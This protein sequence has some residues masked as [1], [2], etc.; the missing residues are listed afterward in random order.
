MGKIPLV[1][2]ILMIGVGAV[3]ETTTMHQSAKSTSAPATSTEADPVTFQEPFPT[4]LLKDLRELLKINTE[5]KNKIGPLYEKTSGEDEDL[6]RE[7]WI[8]N[9]PLLK[10]DIDLKGL[11]GED[12]IKYTEKEKAR[13]PR[14]MKNGIGRMIS[15]VKSLRSNSQNE[16]VVETMNFLLAD[17]QIPEF[18][19]I[20]EKI[21]G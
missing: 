8:I 21:F 1:L 11:L 14:K 2:L 3:P 19:K 7:L 12:D 16:T 6:S 18:L 13:V 10:N 5:M 9:S 17:Q 4:D 20:M 15:R